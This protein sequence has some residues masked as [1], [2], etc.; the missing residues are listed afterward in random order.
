MLAMLLIVSLSAWIDTDNTIRDMM[1][2]SD[3]ARTEREI[4]E[5][6]GTVSREI[7]AENRASDE[8]RTYIIAGAIVAGFIL[9]GLLIR[10]QPRGQLH[11]LASQ[12]QEK[13]EPATEKR[14]ALPI[15][16][17]GVKEPRWKK[18]GAIFA[19]ACA[20]GAFSWP[21]FIESEA[22]NTPLY[23]CGAVLVIFA[24]IWL[25]QLELDSRWT[26][27]CPTCGRRSDSLQNATLGSNVNCKHCGNLFRRP[28]ML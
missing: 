16:P 2:E 5:K 3:R 27:K 9:F 17:W 6:Q 28:R 19:L 13:G 24:L 26:C 18:P 10:A 8:K 1:R 14:Q 15:V 20:V 22:F 12:P 23:A 21:Q 11:E 7:A 25:H 4:Q